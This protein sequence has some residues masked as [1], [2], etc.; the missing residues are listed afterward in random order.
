MINSKE[1]EVMITLKAEKELMSQSSLEI[2]VITQ[3]LKLDIAIT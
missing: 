1:M 2:E 3:F